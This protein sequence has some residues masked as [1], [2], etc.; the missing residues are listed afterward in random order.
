MAQPLS[1]ESK[2]WVY[3]ITTRTAGSRLWLVGNQGLENQILGYLGK[4]QQRYE[5]E[6]YG[7]ILMGNHYHLMASFPKMNRALFMRDFNSAVARAVAPPW[8]NPIR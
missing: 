3:F 4:Y 5:A 1:I 7:F 2:D 6:I 8:L